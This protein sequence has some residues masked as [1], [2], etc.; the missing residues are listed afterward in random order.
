MSFGV[1]LCNNNYNFVLAPYHGP[2]YCMPYLSCNSLHCTAN[3]GTIY[4]VVVILVVAR[5]HGCHHV[6]Y[7]LVCVEN[8][9]CFSVNYSTL[10]IMH[11]LYMYLVPFKETQGHL[12]VIAM[13]GMICSYA[14]IAIYFTWEASQYVHP[15]GGNNVTVSL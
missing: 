1:F 13:Y 15:T 14:L 9:L 8:V 4:N 6:L 2:L 12:H 3:N 7:S 5:V 11:Y 10:C